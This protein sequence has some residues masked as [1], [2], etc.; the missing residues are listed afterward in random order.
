MSKESEVRTMRV[1]TRPLTPSSKMILTSHGA[2]CVSELGEKRISTDE[3][4][5]FP[6][7]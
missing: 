3:F 2:R 5:K 6:E 7:K 1:P 4:N